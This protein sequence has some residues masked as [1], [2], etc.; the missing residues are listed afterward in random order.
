MASGQEYLVLW[1]DLV[2]V[3][4]CKT[5]VF[6]QDDGPDVDLPATPGKRRVERTGELIE[7]GDSRM[8]KAQ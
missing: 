5:V 8:R 3:W 6:V 4:R 2:M 7:G 1:V